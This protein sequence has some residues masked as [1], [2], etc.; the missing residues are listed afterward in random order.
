[1][2]V[3]SQLEVR[4]VA[5]LHWGTHCINS[6]HYGKAPATYLQLCADGNHLHTVSLPTWPDKNGWTLGGLHPSIKG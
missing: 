3:T 2:Q 5:I 4:Q 6:D 1:M